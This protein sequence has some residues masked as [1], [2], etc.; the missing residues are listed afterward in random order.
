MIQCKSRIKNR[1]RRTN[2]HKFSFQER[3]LFELD[4]ECIRKKKK[5][6]DQKAMLC[7]E[8]FKLS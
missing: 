8:N 5:M 1:F 7:L 4:E 2:C 3:I 6:N